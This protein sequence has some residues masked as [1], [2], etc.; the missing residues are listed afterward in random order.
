MSDLHAAT[1]PNPTGLDVT[2]PGHSPRLASTS[3]ALMSYAIATIWLDV[4]ACGIFAPDMI[5]GSEHE[6]LPLAGISDWIFAAAASGLLVTAHTRRRDPSR[7]V[8]L[9][10]A[11]LVGVVWMMVA[12]T[13]IFCPSLVTGTDP[14]TIPLAALLAPVV[15]ALATAYLAVFAAAGDG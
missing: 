13:S 8:W 11:L 3:L 15:G 9:W 1:R 6:H 4:A 2:S 5:T 7:A 14:T 12:L 10:V